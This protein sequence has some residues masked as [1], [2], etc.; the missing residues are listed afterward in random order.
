MHTSGA[1]FQ[2]VSAILSCF[3]YTTLL[4]SLLYSPCRMMSSSLDTLLR[5]EQSIHSYSQYAYT[6]Y[7]VPCHA[8]L[9]SL[10]QSSTVQF[11]DVPV[12]IAEC[13]FYLIYGADA[14]NAAG[15]DE[16]AEEEMTANGRKGDLAG[17]LLAGRGD[18]IGLTSWLESGDES[19]GAI[20]SSSS[21][22]MSECGSGVALDTGGGRGRRWEK[23]TC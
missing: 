17:V 7:S 14:E 10:A 20:R 21:S 3:S 12:A 8:C 15:R 11:N 4:Y 5:C 6:L 9:L 23:S 18:R 1:R 16:A 2:L 13:C 19:I 22:I